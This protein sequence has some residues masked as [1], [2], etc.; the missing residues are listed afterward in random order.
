MDK[1]EKYK[2]IRG[3]LELVSFI[4]ALIIGDRISFYLG[5]E[6]NKFFSRDTAL[7]IGIVLVIALILNFFAVR[8]ADLWY[9]KNM[10]K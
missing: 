9:K 8:T 4:I 2:K 1:I 7:H 6:S 10:D 3:R 5:I